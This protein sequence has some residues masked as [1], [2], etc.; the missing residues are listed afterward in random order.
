MV[1][2]LF[3]SFDGALYRVIRASDNTTAT[4]HVDEAGG[5][6]HSATQDTFCSGT[7]CVSGHRR[8]S[9][10]YSP[11]VALVFVGI[12]VCRLAALPPGQ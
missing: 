9:R 12:F 2:A 11:Y 6:A 5:V 4:I 10:C 3:A 7:D 1:R 8:M